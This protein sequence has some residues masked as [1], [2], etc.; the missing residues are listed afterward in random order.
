MEFGRSVSEQD[1][2]HLGKF[3][4]LARVA[5]GD[6]VSAPL[7][8]VASKPATPLGAAKA[9]RYVSRQNYERFVRQVEAE[10]E[11]RRKPA[12]KPSRPRPKVSGS[13]DGWSDMG[14]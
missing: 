4:C 14:L 8:L 1:F 12:D 5:T 7:T 9:A 2:M 3:E 11:A 13:K 10:M 6:G